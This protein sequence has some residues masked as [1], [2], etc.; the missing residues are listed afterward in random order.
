M[1]SNQFLIF[2]GLVVL[3]VVASFL[4]LLTKKAEPTKLNLR[5]GNK[6]S[7]EEAGLDF[8]GEEELNILFNYNGHLWDAFEV[9]GVPAGSGLEMIERAY[10]QS[11]NSMDRSSR[12]LI[13]LA[14]QAI[15]QRL[16]AQ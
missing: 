7:R 12:E 14:Y 10:E 8:G 2:N 4:M 15:L 16:K 6:P 13:D 11:V 3:L 9:L 5:K 1:S